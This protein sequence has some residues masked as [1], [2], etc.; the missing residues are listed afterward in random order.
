MEDGEQIPP[1]GDQNRGYII[2]VVNSV[3]AALC[4][5]TIAL[6]IY[7]RTR[8]LDNIGPDDYTILVALVSGGVPANRIRATD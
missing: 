5:I 1:G 6:R 4:S 3:L 8:I 2:I 7:I